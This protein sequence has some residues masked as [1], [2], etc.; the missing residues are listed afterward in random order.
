MA[1]DDDSTPVN[2]TKGSARKL[3]RLVDRF[4][5]KGPPGDSALGRGAGWTPSI[6]RAQ[7]TTAIPTGSFASPSSS[8]R[9]K[10]AYLIAGVWT[11]ETDPVEV[12]NDK[13]LASSI[14]VGRAVN[15]AWI[16]G[17][18]WLNIISCS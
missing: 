10:I 6:V 2:L 18:W 17:Q 12:W 5:G 14:P 7:V 9:A 8:G 3:K 13:T 1:K 15:L 16:C 4:D 11:L